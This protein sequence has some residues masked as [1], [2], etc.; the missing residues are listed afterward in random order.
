MDF[1]ITP[2]NNCK[3]NKIPNFDSFFSCKKYHN[4][5]CI[6][7]KKVEILFNLWKAEK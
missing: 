2:F 5:Q 4:L 1:Q 7:L 6:T 3:V